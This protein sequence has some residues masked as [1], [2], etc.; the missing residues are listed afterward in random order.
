VEYISRLLGL[1]GP[2]PTR[3]INSMFRAF[4]PDADTGHQFIYSYDF[5]ADRLRAAGFTD[6]RRQEL[7]ESTHDALRGIERH[8]DVIGDER[9]V[10][11]E[12]LIVEATRP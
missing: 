1:P 5:L 3:V 6:V 2:D 10:R 11:Y 8:T 12:T 9:V 4:G 7:G